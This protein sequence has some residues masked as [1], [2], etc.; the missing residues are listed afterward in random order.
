MGNIYGMI[1]RPDI[2]ALTLPPPAPLVDPFGRAISYIRV[3]VTDRCDFRCVYCMS[4]DMNFLPKGDLLTLDDVAGTVD[5][6]VPTSLLLEGVALT[7]TAETLN[8]LRVVSGWDDLCVVAPAAI[9][10]NR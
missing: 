2:D 5:F 1:L 10:P 3:S 9:N 8:A 6:P 7:A 4:E